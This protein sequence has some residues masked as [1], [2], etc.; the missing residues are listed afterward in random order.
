MTFST[1]CLAVANDLGRFAIAVLLRL[2]GRAAALRHRVRLKVH[3]LRERRLRQRLGIGPSTGITRDLPD[4]DAAAG[5]GDSVALTSGTAGEPKRVA[6]SKRRLAATRAVFVDGMLRL[7]AARRVR[8]PSLYVFGALDPDR[9]LS[10]LLVRERRAPA[11]CVLL[12]APYRAQSDPA[13]LELKER[14]G[15]S[16]LR[17]LVL[18]LANPGMLYATN[19]STLSAF[20]EE[21]EGDWEASGAL[22]RLVVRD[23]RRVSPGARRIL[24]RLA[25]RGSQE[26]LERVAGSASPLP[27]TTWN[28][29]FTTYVCWTGGAVT[30]FLERLDRRLPAPRF[31][32][33]PMYSMSTETVAT[34]P[35]YRLAETAFLP[36]APGVVHEFLGESGARLRGARELEPGA[37]YEMVVTHRFGLRRYATGDRFRVERF[38]GGLPD[39]RFAGRRGR[40]WS[41]TGEKLTAGQVDRALRMLEAEHPGLCDEGWLALFPSNPGGAAL[42]CYRLAALGADSAGLPEGLPERFDELLG[43]LNLEYRA[44]RASGRLG[45]VRLSVVDRPGFLRRATGGGPAHP[46]AQFKFERFYPRLWEE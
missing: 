5:E 9:S 14:Y 1:G 19:P 40:G 2:A 46:D 30:P 11:W 23:P 34:I 44:K 42:P 10:S 28:P 33:E 26:R 38:V 32:R 25:S 16:A 31:R 15:A 29:A 41:F 45:E 24:W 6:Y 12:Q 37:V 36:A 22:V 18:T 21:V 3:P 43:D 4:L 39:L 13:L 27:I 8:R 20:L 7:V 17:L 35:D